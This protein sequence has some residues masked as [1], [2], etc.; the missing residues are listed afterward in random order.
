ML[1][2]FKAYVEN[3]ADLREISRVLKAR[4]KNHLFVGHLMPRHS[5]GYPQQVRVT[6]KVERTGHP[7]RKCPGCPLAK[8][9]P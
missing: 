6:L 5:P 7:R 9:Y 3:G 2:S 8:E 1:R 4:L